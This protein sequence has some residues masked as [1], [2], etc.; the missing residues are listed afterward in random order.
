MDQDVGDAIKLANEQDTDADALHLARAAKIVR[1]DILKQAQSF[2]GTFDTDCQENSI[3]QSLKALIDFILRGPSSHTN[4]AT[5]ESV[6]V[7]E[8]QASR[9][10]SQLIIYNTT[11]RQTKSASNVA[12]HSRERET[13]L[14]IYVA[15]K[16]HGLTRG[17][18]LIDALFNLGLCISYDRV[19]SISTDIANS[20][21]E[22]FQNDGVVC[23][24]ILRSELFTTAGFD[25][26]DHNPSST[27]ARDSFHGTAISL[28]QHPT[29]QW[30]G[31]VR[32]VN[33]IDGLPQKERK[34]S[35][36]PPQ[37]TD[38]HPV[39]LIEQDLSP[40]PIVGQLP[41]ADSEKDYGYKKEI[42]W[43]DNVKELLKK[44]KLN[45]D[46]NF[47]WAS[48]HASSELQLDYEPAIT[49][50]MPLFLENA[51]SAPMIIHGMNVI[52]AAVELVNQ[53]QTP[54]I[55][56]DQ[57]LFA[58]A[59]QIQWQWPPTHG[60][61]KFLIMFG[62]LH[63][64]LAMLRMLGKWL[65]K[66]GWTTVLVNAGVASPGVA[67]SFT[68]A[69]HITKTRR[70][71]QITSAS[72]YIL[73]QRAYEKYIT[74]VEDSAPLSFTDW[75]DEMAKM[76]PHF[77]Y[78]CR[79]MELQLL[80]LQLVKA[81]R[82]ADF[83]LYV[84]TLTKVM[85]W[86]FALDQTNYC[87]WLP[88]HIRDM[89]ELPIKHPDVYEKFTSGFFAVHKTKK[90]FSAMALDQAH[91]QENA[92]VKG[93]GGAVGLTENPGALKRWMISGPEIARIVN[94]FEMTIATFSDNCQKH[95]E[96]S[97]GHQVAFMKD[98]QSVIDS[99]EELGNPFMEK[100]KDL[101]AVDTKD[102]MNNDVVEAVKNV[103][104]LGQEQYSSYVERRLKRRTTP[105]SDPIKK[106]QLPLFSN[107]NQKVQSKDK[108]KIVQLKNDCSLF[109]RLYI[110]CQNRDG[111][112]QEF[113]RHENQPWPPS[114]AD[115]EKSGKVRKR[116]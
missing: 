111:N 32:E 85:P 50:L 66:S 64:E 29:E 108:S 41:A 48:F 5:K 21:C 112:L 56:M 9:S 93:E 67:D 25:N 45:S 4:T 30:S 94:E 79:V 97:Y 78:W 80:C 75:K 27:T 24:P 10:I 39:V 51:H 114:L 40:P 90:R 20:V 11:I 63:I 13:P 61:D 84:D 72:L 49:S 3:P 69:K 15:L 31:T 43:L 77:L 54:V 53:G 57:P 46:E 95:H 19:L 107:S 14:P 1:K 98:V 70:A 71:H 42:Q 116:I 52:R 62:G 38:V 92:V 74:R 55:A 23:P 44:E 58:L 7:N 99:F 104:K 28:V 86:M 103:V 59:K 8:N 73:Q 106:N 87:R 68:S 115:R 105:I 109:S 2:K 96:Q 12:R 33:V 76:C 88:V 34:V 36:L 18:N 83:K 100:G 35:S 22:R 113:F 47:S 26:I 91:E 89:Q 110:A 81:F 16:I 82:T 60:E 17:R 101:L 102:I 37:F 65:N 6:E